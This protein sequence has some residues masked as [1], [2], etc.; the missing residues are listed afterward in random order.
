MSGRL[1][2]ARRE[3]LGPGEFT[4]V[5]A[6]MVEPS[7]RFPEGVKFAFVYV[8][9]AA[10]RSRRVYGIDNAHGALHEHR[11][12]AT[13]PLPGLGLEEARRRFAREVAALREGSS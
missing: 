12:G 10:S 9:S 8:T 2:F 7:T 6:W 11:G 5:R 1:L 13:T 3:Q 4:E